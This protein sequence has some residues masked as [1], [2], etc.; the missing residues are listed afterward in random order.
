MVEGNNRGCP[1]GVENKT[2]IDALHESFVTFRDE[3]RCD[4]RKLVNHYSGRPSWSI[5]VIV[6]LLTTMCGALVVYIATH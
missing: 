1:L 4:I 2:R 6:T 5:M 3:V